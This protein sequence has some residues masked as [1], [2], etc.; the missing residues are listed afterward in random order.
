MWQRVQ[1]QSHVS[2]WELRVQRGGNS[3]HGQLCRSVNELCELRDVWQYVRWWHELSGRCLRMSGRPRELRRD[4]SCARNRSRQ[5]WILWP[6]MCSRSDLC[7]GSLRLP[8]GRGGLLRDLSYGLYR[9]EQLRCVRHSMPRWRHVCRW[10]VPLSGRTGFLRG[11]LRHAGYGR[12]QLR[13]VWNALRC[14]RKRAYILHRWV[15]RA[16]DV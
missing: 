2:R 10:D 14:S 1:R 15:L 11:V 3:V 13:D 4:V 9:R 12:K 7:V 8:D 5:L 6:P 16:R